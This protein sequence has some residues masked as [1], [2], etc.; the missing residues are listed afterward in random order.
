MKSVMWA[1]ET[2]SDE[3][4]ES[5]LGSS[6]MFPKTDEHLSTDEGEKH[7]C[8]IVFLIKIVLLFLCC[9]FFS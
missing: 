8:L 2:S 7:I 4:D 3:D 6:P 1:G 5:Q 9:C